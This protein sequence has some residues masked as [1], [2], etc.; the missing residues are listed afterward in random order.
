MV[1]E[2]G[3][4][5]SAERRLGRYNIAKGGRIGYGTWR[6]QNITEGRKP[7]HLTVLGHSNNLNRDEI[8]RY[9][10]AVHRIILVDRDG[11]VNTDERAQRDLTRPSRVRD[12]T[13]GQNLLWRVSL[14]DRK[15]EIETEVVL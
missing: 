15:R 10:I 4:V 3:S 8:E 13:L 12:V 14:S 5:L 9:K 6:E 7:L 11:A 2:N 1:F